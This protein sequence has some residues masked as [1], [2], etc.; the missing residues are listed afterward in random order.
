MHKC[1]FYDNHDLC[2]LV[3][4]SRNAMH[5]AH[6]DLLSFF[7]ASMRLIYI[8]DCWHFIPATLYIRLTRL[9]KIGTPPLVVLIWLVI[10]Y[11]LYDFLYLYN[12]GRAKDVIK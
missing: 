7:L 6:F 2:P 4:N 5:H 12:K 8:S 11:Y 3:L 9:T 10:S 1:Q